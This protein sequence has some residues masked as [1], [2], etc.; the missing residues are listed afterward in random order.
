M[1]EE[2]MALIELTDEGFIGKMAG[3]DFVLNIS[4]T[5]FNATDLM[6]ISIGYCFGITVDAYAKH[7]GLNISNLKINVKGKK[8]ETENRY[9]KIDIEV[10]FDGDLTPEQ[11]ERVIVIGKRGCTVSNSMLKAPEINVILL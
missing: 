10:S 3:K 11:R 7:K 5:T 2:K 4:N 6:L 8:H 9:E 1:A